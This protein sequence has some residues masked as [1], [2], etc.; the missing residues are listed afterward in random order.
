M[1]A[2]GTHVYRCVDI[3]SNMCV[4]IGVMGLWGRVILHARRCKGDGGRGVGGH[5]V[6]V[7]GLL[8]I[9]GLGE[10]KVNFVEGSKLPWF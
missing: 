4:C 3:S 2:S 7:E 10:D 6:W 1:R 8:V 9:S 5:C